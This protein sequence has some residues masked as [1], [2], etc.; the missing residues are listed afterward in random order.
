MK[1]GKKF[2]K[3]DK[4]NKIVNFK[5]GDKKNEIFKIKNNNNYIFNCNVISD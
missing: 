1:G 5:K 2:I 3:T 4:N